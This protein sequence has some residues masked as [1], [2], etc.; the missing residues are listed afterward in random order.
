MVA[1]SGSMEIGST[2]NRSWEPERETLSLPPDESGFPFY[3]FSIF[4]ILLVVLFLCFDFPIG[5]HHRDSYIHRSD[6]IAMFSHHYHE[7]NTRVPRAKEK[8]NKNK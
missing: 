1:D 5:D 7:I 4:S 2:W 3:F 6:P 8:N